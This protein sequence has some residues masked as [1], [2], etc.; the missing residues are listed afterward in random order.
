MNNTSRIRRLSTIAILASIL[1]NVAPGV[2]ITG[3]DWGK[4]WVVDTS[5][6]KDPVDEYG[7]LLILSNTGTS[8]ARISSIELIGE[9][10]EAGY[11]LLDTSVRAT[12]ILVGDEV[13]P[14][15]DI[16]Q[17]VIFRPR[18]E[19]SYLATI[20]V[21]TEAGDTTQN[22]LTGVGIESHGAVTDVRFDTIQYQGSWPGT[23]EA[24]MRGS[25]TAKPTRPLTITGIGVDS[26]DG[27]DFTIAA[28]EL[29]RLPL[30]LKPG[31]TT[32]FD[33][34]FHPTRAG[35]HRARIF[36]TGDHSFCDDSTGAV[37][38][39]VIPSSGVDRAEDAAAFTLDVMS[40]IDG[41]VA[42]RY[43]LPIPAD[44][45]IE[46]FDAIGGRI[47]VIAEGRSD[48]GERTVVWDGARHPSGVYYCR[49]LSGGRQR[50]VPILLDR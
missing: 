22:I 44:A 26:A 2:E 8:N 48:A 29:A 33:V 16:R 47:E 34:I 46:I 7:A 30:T 35:L 49:I 5:C 40:A 12:T 37:E 25:I 19:R 38:A 28:A 18:G 1:T 11:F 24:R 15:D 17:R 45:R 9:D 10:A 3:N 23:P 31:E 36:F 20:R 21:I 6:T 14:G 50:T 4:R 41:K 32:T 43:R 39:Y 42:I 27:G 13:R